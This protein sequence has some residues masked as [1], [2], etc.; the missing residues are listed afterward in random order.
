MH[1]A[2]KFPSS[3]RKRG[4][5]CLAHDAAPA[6]EKRG[7]RFRGDDEGWVKELGLALAAVL[8]LFAIPAAAR[9]AVDATAPSA[10]A[11][12]LYRDPNRGPEQAMNR[13]WPQGFAMIT[14]TRTVTLPPGESTIRFT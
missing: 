7:P 2:L 6:G 5:R 8:F 1:F 14:E 4:P 9:E 13:N 3:P 10:L 12:T 11:V